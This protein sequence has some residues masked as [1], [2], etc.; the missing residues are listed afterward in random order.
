MLFSTK[1]RK[2]VFRKIDVT[3]DLVG[4][5]RAGKRCGQLQCCVSRWC[6]FDK[7]DFEGKGIRLIIFQTF[8]TQQTYYIVKV[9]I[10]KIAVVTLP[11]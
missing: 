1:N 8:L 10:V 3:F 7:I 2:T 5:V 4:V 11:C 6:C 9:S